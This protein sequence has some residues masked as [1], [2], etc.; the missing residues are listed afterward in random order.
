MM[1][2]LSVA[3]GPPQLFHSRVE[4][5]GRDMGAI[6]FAVVAGALFAASIHWKRLRNLSFYAVPLAATLTPLIAPSSVSTD[7]Y[8][9]V[10]FA[11]SLAAGGCFA[12]SGMIWQQELSASHE[13]E[14][15][16][17]AQRDAALDADRQKE[18][19]LATLDQTL[20]ATRQDLLGKEASIEALSLHAM[21]RK[22]IEERLKKLK[23]IWLDENSLERDCSDALQENLWILYPDYKPENSK[24]GENT[25][26]AAILDSDFGEDNFPE[27]VAEWGKNFR[28]SIQAT[29][30]PDLFGWVDTS[31]SLN[32]EGRRRYLIIELKRAQC[33]LKWEHVEQ[34]HAYAFALIQ[35]GGKELR[36]CGIDCLVIGKSRE[37]LNHA[38]LRWGPEHDH[39]IRIIPV[40]YKELY[41]RAE[42]F[43]ELLLRGGVSRI[44]GAMPPLTSQ[45]AA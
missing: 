32:H 26:L 28:L 31:A 42:K 30:R 12:L 22:K 19:R 15:Q 23:K 13:R 29:C 2:H 3:T 8:W 25:G 35:N 7:F 16:I 24:L 9:G 40:T 10:V 43:V 21:N 33:P 18:G 6:I 1:R 37:G 27:K 41:D 38:H 5:E 44:A 4:G 14:E 39:S 45:K 11:L 34:V 36:H 20:N 17:A